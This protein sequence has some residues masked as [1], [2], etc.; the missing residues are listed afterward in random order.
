MPADI[1]GDDLTWAVGES[2]YRAALE[3]VAEFGPADAV[4]KRTATLVPDPANPD[5]PNA[6]K[7]LIGGEQVGHLPREAAAVIAAPLA[8]LVEEQGEVTTAAE[9]HG[10]GH[11]SGP[12]P[13]GA[14]D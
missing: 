7:V 13:D 12:V 8:K 11:G 10:S 9:I 1:S 5:D 4:R 14:I 3:K 2:Y 6:V